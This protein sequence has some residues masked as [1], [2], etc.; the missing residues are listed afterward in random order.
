MKTKSKI[1]KGLLFVPILLYLNSNSLSNKIALYSKNYPILY[2]ANNYFYKFMD[3][4]NPFVSELNL[5]SKEIINIDINI[6]SF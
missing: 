6:N 2:T 3:V 4:F 1:L 5:A